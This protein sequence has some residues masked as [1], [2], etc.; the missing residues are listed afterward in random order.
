MSIQ[1]RLLL[2]L[3]VGAPLVWL[4]AGL[5]SIRFARHEVDELFDTELIRTVRGVGYALGAA[6]G[7]EP[8]PA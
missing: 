5:V 1:K 7:E 4:L 2:Y 8:E 6:Q 3:L